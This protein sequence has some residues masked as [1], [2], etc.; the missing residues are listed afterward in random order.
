MLA[1]PL[2]THLIFLLYR[3]ISRYSYIHIFTRTQEGAGTVEDLIAGVD[4][5]G[6]GEIDYNEFLEMMR[7]K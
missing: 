1:L 4:T 3:A 6:D 2:L 7:A 5:D